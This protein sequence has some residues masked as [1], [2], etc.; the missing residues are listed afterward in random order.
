MIKIIGLCGHSGSGK[1]Y[2]CGIFSNYGIPSI[3]TDKVYSYLI[4]PVDGYPSPCV[5]ELIKAF[6]DVILNADNSLNRRA[7]S[8]IV[9]GSDGDKLNVLN[10][11][12]HKYILIKTRELIAEYSVSGYK[13][14]II[15]AP[16]L[17]ESGFDKICDY[18]V[19]VTAPEEVSI[20]RIV[21][22]DMISTDSAV[23]RLSHQKSDDELRELCDFEIVNDNLADL[24][25][26]IE[27]FINRFLYEAE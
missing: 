7:L 21:E 5:S 20:G 17:F 15:D 4:E 2:V 22:R 23:R 10:E 11:I 8:D 14:V 6:G 25:P 26:Q 12:T 3:D 13:C 24:K 27:T 9:F 1:G 16:V 19:A 18:T